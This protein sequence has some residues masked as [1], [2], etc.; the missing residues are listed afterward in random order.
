MKIYIDDAYRCHVQNPDGAY[1]AVE[2]QA[3]TDKCKTY[4]EGFRFVPAGSS[5]TR[6]DGT[7]FVGEMFA[8]AVDVVSLLLAQG[9]Y[10]DALQAVAALL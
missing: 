1:T 10:E 3:F 2:T 9:A 4:I 6:N 7:V 5:W 8:P